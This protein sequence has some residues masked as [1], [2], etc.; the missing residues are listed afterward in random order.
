MSNRIFN[1]ISSIV[2]LLV[3]LAGMWFLILNF[4]PPEEKEE[5]C[6]Y[7]INSV[8]AKYCKLLGEYEPSE[9]LYN[10]ECNW[11]S[12][13]EMWRRN[14]N[15]VYND[16]IKAKFWKCRVVKNCRSSDWRFTKPEDVCEYEYKEI[17]SI[18]NPVTF[19]SYGGYCEI[20]K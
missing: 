10:D 20:L 3:G 2:I 18:E 12:Q 19:E 1:L 8:L 16:E 11:Y 15:T 14:I 13:E 17:E 9:R 7:K 6:T 4:P 5:N